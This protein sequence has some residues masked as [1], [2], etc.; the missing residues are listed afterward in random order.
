LD[1]IKV[2]AAIIV[3]DDK[4]LIA[5]RKQGKHLEFKWEFPGG[6]IEEGESEQGALSR[7]LMEEFGIKVKVQ[8][9]VTESFYTYEKVKVNLRAYLVRY[10]EGEFNPVDHD[11]IKWISILDQKQYD[12]APADIPINDYL[13]KHGIQIN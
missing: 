4:I 1:Y 3:K 12:F 6:K 8:R 7:E 5:R 2:A 9:F 13:L 10:L 11:E